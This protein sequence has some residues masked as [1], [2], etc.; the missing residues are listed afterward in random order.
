MM[1]MRKPLRRAKDTSPLS[2]CGWSVIRRNEDER[3]RLVLKREY[4]VGSLF[5]CERKESKGQAQWSSIIRASAD[6]IHKPIPKGVTNAF[7]G[8]TT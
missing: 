7:T 2:Y 1:R 6:R 8:K 3:E 5:M 4:V